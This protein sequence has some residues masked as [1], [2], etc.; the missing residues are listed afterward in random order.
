MKDPLLAVD[1]GSSVA[2]GP[3]VTIAVVG[4]GQRG[5]ASVCS[6][7]SNNELTL[8]VRLTA[9]MQYIHQTTLKS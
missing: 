5:K 6:V 4:C 2:V 7:P 8:A 1:A 9:D 3:P